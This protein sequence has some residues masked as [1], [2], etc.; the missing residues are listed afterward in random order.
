[1]SVSYSLHLSSKDKYLHTFLIYACMLLLWKLGWYSL[2]LAVESWVVRF[3]GGWG[4]GLVSASL[5]DWYS[6]FRYHHVVR[7]RRTPITP[8]RGATFQK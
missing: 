1:M 3:F 8:W 2:L 4:R 7:K 6:G 5:G